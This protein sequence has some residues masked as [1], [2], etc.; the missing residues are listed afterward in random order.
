MT[1][2]R[3][4]IQELAAECRLGVYDWEQEKPQAISIDL[5][6]AIDAARAAKRDDVGEAVD[7]ARL[8]STITALAQSRAFRLVETLAESIASLALSEF[9]VAWVRVRV[10][11]RALP[12]IG[13]AAVEIERRAMRSRRA[14]RVAGRRPL[15][16]SRP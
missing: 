7:Y 14:R 4:I 6:L 15:A 1:A 16:A 5:E 8:V 13:Y 12:E 10:K 9:G 2:D 3:L 11:K